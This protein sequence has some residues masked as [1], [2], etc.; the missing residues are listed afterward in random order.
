MLICSGHLDITNKIS[1]FTIENFG[2][3]RLDVHRRGFSF[4]GL[5]HK[6]T[7]CATLHIAVFPRIIREL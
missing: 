6:I 5:R 7:F 1:D 4:I 2:I 3:I